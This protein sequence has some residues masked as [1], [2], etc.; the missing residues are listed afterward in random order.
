M[1][2]QRYIEQFL[3]YGSL[4][5]PLWFVGMEEA[6]GKSTEELKRRVAVWDELGGDPVVDLVDFHQ[7]IGCDQYFG[8]RPKRQVTWARL[9]QIV[10]TL[11]GLDCGRDAVLALQSQHLGRKGGT[12]LL[13]E[14]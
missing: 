9:A 12:T 8:V 11:E 1:T 7:R 14:L 2:L 6:G 10:L 3:G 4:S 5:A 13:A